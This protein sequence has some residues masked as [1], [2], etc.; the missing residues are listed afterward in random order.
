MTTR[1]HRHLRESGRKALVPY[2]TAGVV[3]NWTEYLHSYIAGGADAIEIGLPFSDPM[4]DG[5]TIQQASDISLRRGT[6]ADAVLDQLA[7]MQLTVPLVVMT[8][9]N[10]VAH[11][12]VD[13]F[14]AKLRAANVDGLIIPDA[15]VE[16]LALVAKMAAEYEIGL[17][18]MVGPSSSSQRRRMIAEHSTGFV[19]VASLMGT[20][21]ERADLSASAA[22]LAREVRSYSATPALIG[23][24]ISTPSQAGAAAESAD[25]VI[26]GSALIR[27]ILDGAS[28]SE[29]VSWLSSF[30]TVLDAHTG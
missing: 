9:Y 5:Q 28:P 19:Y 1:L 20:T 7:A 13:S 3:D 23:M 8:Y 25:G 17:V 24:G 14:F 16:E 30:R 29:V 21:G 6:T 2:L 27:Q 4:I 12:T 11:A 18:L 10:L 22:P 15:P 26:I